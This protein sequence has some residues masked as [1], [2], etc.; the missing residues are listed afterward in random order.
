MVWLMLSANAAT[1]PERAPSARAVL[2]AKATVRIISA[3]QLK[4]DS[5]TNPQAPPAHDS[6]VTADGRIQSARLIEFE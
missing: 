6:K 4:L 3:I 5:P 1:V 2:E